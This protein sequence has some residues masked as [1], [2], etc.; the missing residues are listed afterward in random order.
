MSPLLGRP[1]AA[2][3]VPSEPLILLLTMLIPERHFVHR[4]QVGFGAGLDHVRAGRFAGGRAA[5][6]LDLD[7][8]LANGIF[9][10]GDRFDL[11]IDQTAGDACNAVDSLVSGIDRAVADGGVLQDDI[12]LAQPHRGS[13]HRLV[14]R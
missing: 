9:A 2:P 4:V 5:V 13:R 8:H 14:A 11:I 10:T 7:M 1:A 6:E 12:I 3:S